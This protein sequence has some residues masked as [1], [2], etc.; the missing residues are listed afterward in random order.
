MVVRSLPSRGRGGLVSSSSGAHA[1]HRRVGL[2]VG[3][4]SRLRPSIRLV[5]SQC[6]SLFHQPLRASGCLPCHPGLSPSPPGQVSVSVHRQYVSSVLPAQGRGHALLHAE[7]RGSGHP[8]PMRGLRCSSAPPVCSGSPECLS[9]LSQLGWPSPLF[10]MDSPQGSVS[11]SFPPLAGHGGFIR[12]LHQPLPPG[13]FFPYGRSSGGGGGCSDPILGS[14]SGLRLP[15]VQPYPEGAL[16][17]PRLPQSGADS[18]GSV[19]ATPALV[20]GSPRPASGGPGPS[21]TSGSAPSA[22]L[23]PV[24]REPPRAG[25][26]WVMHCK[27]SSRHFGF[28]E[29]VARQLAS[30]RHPSTRLNYQSKWSTYRAWCHSHGH[31]VSRPTV[32][33]VADFLLYL[34]RS[35]HLS[36]S[37]IA[38][39][40]SV[41]SAAFRFVLPEL[42][43]HPVLHDLLHS[44]R[45]ERPLPS[46]RFPPWDLL[47]V[48]SLLRGSPFEPLDSCSLRDLT[49]KTLFLLSLATARHVGELQAFFCCVFFWWGPFPFLPSRIP[50]QIGIL[51]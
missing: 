43:S 6:L 14:S 17:G 41:L 23:P 24:S 3:C 22:P 19:L 15:S 4:V 50:R 29:R 26:D 8:S 28:S 25:A 34:R 30:S 42:S 36:Y 13:V 2:R 40:R 45:V 35:L 5:V 49:H 18:S 21:S 20:S 27:R 31:S 48:L 39:Y 11:R 33:K 37:T 1:L 47:R 44:F 12:H 46:S 10:R 32:P 51:F 38:S 7:L 16:Q 9:R